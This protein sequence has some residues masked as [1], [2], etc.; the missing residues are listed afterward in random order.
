LRLVH[1]YVYADRILQSVLEEA[2]PDRKP[3][4]VTVEVGEMLGLTRASLTM[5]YEVPSKGTMA[6]GSKL[7]VK[8]SRGSVNCPKCG[9]KGRLRVS[10]HGHRIDPTFACPKCGST[11][12]AESGLDVQLVSVS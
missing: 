10:R 11:L 4:E 9:F 8:F 7:A 1:E 3:T 6:E 12:R 5:A 2:G